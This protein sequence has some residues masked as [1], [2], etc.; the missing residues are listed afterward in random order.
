MAS[1]KLYLDSRYILQSKYSF[2]DIAEKTIGKVS[3]ILLNLLV[4]V[5]LFGVLTLY[6][7]LFSRIAISVFGSVYKPVCTDAPLLERPQICTDSIWNKKW[8]YV[9]ILAAIQT[10]II[11]KKRLNELNFTT[12]VLFV[13]VILL[14][15]MLITKVIQQDT[16][17]MEGGRVFPENQ[18]VSVE[19]LIDSLNIAVASYGFVI[20]LFPIQSGMAKK[21]DITKSVTMSLTFVIFAYTMLGLLS[22]L[23]F[24]IVNVKP[25][26]FENLQED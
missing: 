16:S 5:A 9:L 21:S 19:A 18:T 14:I 24:G 10:P 11:I 3:G 1:T 8:I 20:N 17:E 4:A 2:S 6:M 15:T 13:G 25:S 23:S 26:I 12:Y 7:I 22:A